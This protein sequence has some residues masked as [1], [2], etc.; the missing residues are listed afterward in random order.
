MSEGLTGLIVSPAPRSKVVFPLRRRTGW[1]N[2]CQE[3]EQSLFLLI[4]SQGGIPVLEEALTH[5]GITCFSALT[6]C[7]GTRD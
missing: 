6:V 3:E 4:C 7:Q 1:L 2:C 5:L